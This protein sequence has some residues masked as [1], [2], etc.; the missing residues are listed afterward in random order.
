MR[1][2]FLLIVCL[3]PLII[4]CDFTTGVSRKILNAQDF[5]DNQQY[6]KAI[7]EYEVILELNPSETIKF[8]IFYQMAE[9]YSLYLINGEK[10]LRY[11]ELIEN[12]LADNKLKKSAVIK[13][14]KLCFDL[15]KYNRAVIYFENFIESEEFSEE[16]KNYFGMQMGISYYEMNDLKNARRVLGKISETKDNPYRSQSLFYLGQT[17]SLQYDYDKAISLWEKSLE[18]ERESERKIET[19]FYIANS[20]ER[21]NKLEKA[22]K[23]YY[24][25]IDFYPNPEII[26]KR[27]ERIY[28]RKV[29]RRR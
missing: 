8:K 24:S 10:A 13:A 28:Q 17:Y 2:Q 19:K 23:Y 5:V 18:L 26:K 3:I 9:I 12:S 21:Q 14:S 6:Q 16:E 15:K 1:N 4:S 25:I 27:L 22:Y 11:Y 29:S 20:Y 7:D